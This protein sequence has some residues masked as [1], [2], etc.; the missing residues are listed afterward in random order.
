MKAALKG[1]YV[2]FILFMGITEKY[3]LWFENLLEEC[4]YTDESRYTFYVDKEERRPDYYEKKLIEDYSVII[5]K[6]TGEIHIT[7][8]DVFQEMYTTFRH[9]AFTNSGLAAF[10][11]DCIDY[12]EC[13]GGML[14]IG[15]PAWFYEFFTESLNLPNEETI[16]FS[17]NDEPMDKRPF[18]KVDEYGG[19]SVK[20]HCVFLRNKF[21]EIR[22]ML[23]SDFIKH[24]DT[25]PDNEPIIWG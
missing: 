15:Y 8:Y 19:V 3:P 16:Y 4:T 5:R 13:K 17:D 20:N 24:Y 23:Y 14:E 9:D 21:G 6:T 2:E 7:D 10:K 12:V 1:S 18:L 25:D 22:G 11:D